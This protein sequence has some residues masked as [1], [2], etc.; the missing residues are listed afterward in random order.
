MSRVESGSAEA[1]SRGNGG[2]SRG[3]SMQTAHVPVVSVAKRR[4]CLS[5]FRRLAF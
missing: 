5:C 2:L 4:P 1:K 3:L